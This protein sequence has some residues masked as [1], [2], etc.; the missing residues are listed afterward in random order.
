MKNGSLA[1][2]I[3]KE[4]VYSRFDLSLI[5]E[6]RQ[7]WQENR[8]CNPDYELHVILRG[9]GTVDVESERYTLCQQAILI[10]PGVYHLPRSLPGEF[11]RFSFSFFP[12]DGD[13]SDSL[14]KQVPV[15]AVFPVTTELMHLC[16]HFF[17]EYETTALF[18]GEMRQLLLKAVLIRTF[19]QLGLSDRPA[20]ATDGHSEP[21]R[22]T[23]IDTFF[24]TR[25]AEPITQEMLSHRLSLS[26][27]Q[28]SRILKANYGMT[29][30]EKLVLTRMDHAACLLRTTT[31]RISD[32]AGLVG[33][34]SE[35]PFYKMFRRYF[36]TTP[37]DYRK[38]SSQ[39]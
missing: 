35:A 32:I 29:F 33:Y 4:T 9:T 20:A 16:Q 8:H 25:F 15:C 14:A 10:A 31:Q 11:E 23:V 2:S 3:G 12:A 1:L 39:P 26:T 27:R 18:S 37:Q 28:L 17:R 6:S 5:D 36:H 7:V 38:R 21:E 34:A 19:R 13:L 22:T 24:E 30:Q